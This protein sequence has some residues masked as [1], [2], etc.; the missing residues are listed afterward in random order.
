MPQR[1]LLV[2]ADIRESLTQL[3]CTTTTFTVILIKC[4]PETTIDIKVTRSNPWTLQQF[5]SCFLQL[6]GLVE[7]INTSSSFSF[8]LFFF[9]FLFLFSFFNYGKQDNKNNFTFWSPQ[10]S[11]IQETWKTKQQ[12]KWIIQESTITLTLKRL[13]SLI[14]PNN[15]NNS[16]Y[17]HC[18]DYCDFLK[19]I[20]QQFYKTS[21]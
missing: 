6:L 21:L 16:D 4:G 20:L 2:D 7:E 17:L 12:S 14:I 13:T 9:F 11:I 15:N 10:L 8:F 19:I 1:I 3:L 5:F 18:L